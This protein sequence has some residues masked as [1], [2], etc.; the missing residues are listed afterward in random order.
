[1]G[2][3]KP[4]LIRY[5]LTSDEKR[6]SPE[7]FLEKANQICSIYHDAPE[8]N[9]QGCHVISADEMTGIQALERVHPDKP[10]TKGRPAQIEFEYERHGTLSLIAF[11]DIVS[12][13]I[14][15]PYIN[16]T[17]TEKDFCAAIQ[18][19]VKT[20]AENEWIFICDGLNTHKSEGLVRL[21]ASQCGINSELG[22]KGK[23]GILKNM[24]SRTKFLCDATHRIHFAYTPKHSSWL[25]QV[26][27]WFSIL[28]RRLLKR[29]SYGST[30]ELSESISKFIEQYNVTAKAFKWTYKGLPL[31]K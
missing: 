31:T 1:M 6:E 19:L 14:V 27:I 23:S 8:N 26:E 16:K 10:V 7:T 20:D 25:N 12:G 21:I 13:R 15:S 28:T 22:V 30:D 5:W 24:T 3:I 18:E 11:L 2:E 4:H 9:E 29:S 17:R